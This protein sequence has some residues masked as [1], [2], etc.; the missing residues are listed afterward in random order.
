MIRRRTLAVWLVL[1]ACALASAQATKQVKVLLEFRQTAAQNRDALESGG[2]I[3]IERRGGGASADLGATSRETRVRRSTGIFT[4]VQDGGASTLNVAAR[5]PYRE[6][7]F[8]RDYATGAGYLAPGIAFENVG[9]ALRVRA[10]ILPDDRVRLRLTPTVSH[11]SA[12][13]S[14]TIELTEATSEL[15]VRSGEPVTIGG[16]TSDT[17][18]VTREI[19]GIG[20][21]TGSSE[22]HLVLTATIQ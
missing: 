8:L 4:L 22:T 15:E 13:G 16:S 18:E 3:V 20:R 12:D 10:W 5:I 11:F 9:T 2:S 7:I 21:T 1:A 14:G 17:S 6:A 19:L